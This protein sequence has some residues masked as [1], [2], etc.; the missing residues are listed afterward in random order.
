LDDSG[1]PSGTADWFEQEVQRHIGML[2]RQ[3]CRMTHDPERA[4]DLLQDTLER[5]YRKRRLF[6]PGTDV[7]AW[8]LSI[9]RNEWVSS[10]RRQA[11]RPSTVSLDG[12]DDAAFVPEVR[13]GTPGPSAVETLVVDVLSANAI[14]AVIATLSPQYRDVLVLA[15]VHG[16][17]YREIAQQL[18]I[19]IGSVC[20]RLSRA[21][22]R[23][24]ALLREHGH[25]EGSLARAG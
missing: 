11:S 20:S 19:P 18:H 21:R 22:E 6:Q 12:L 8:L 15:D 3:A 14:L 25:L 10:Y 23:L 5:G 9:M 17:P 4:D 24:R 16:T 2:Y 7:R 13:R 1:P